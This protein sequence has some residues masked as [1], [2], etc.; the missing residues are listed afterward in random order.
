MLLR[1][2]A[3]AAGERIGP[4]FAGQQDK[5]SDNSTEFVL[6]IFV[7]HSRGHGRNLLRPI[8]QIGR[9]VRRILKLTERPQCLD[10]CVELIHGIGIQLDLC[11]R[12]GQCDHFPHL[13][14]LPRTIHGR[15]Q[16]CRQGIGR[17]DLRQRR[18]IARH[19][20][21]DGPDDLAL[22]A[23]E[24]RVGLLTMRLPRRQSPPGS[25]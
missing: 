22:H 20:L 3:S 12:D 10:A 1:H 2:E 17:L 5:Q 18:T 13:I 8:R 6:M 14:H 11:S 15:A 21:L 24:L 25:G 9:H 7:S 4:R 16:L 23:P 19:G